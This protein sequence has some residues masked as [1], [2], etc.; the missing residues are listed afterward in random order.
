MCSGYAGLAFGTRRVCITC[1]AWQAAWNN[2]SWTAGR[3][4]YLF[5]DHS[6]SK[7]CRRASL[8]PWVVPLLHSTA[9]ATQRTLPLAAA[10]R[11]A[12]LTDGPSPS[13]DV[14]HAAEPAGLG[15]A[16]NAPARAAIGTAQRCLACVCP[17]GCNLGRH[18]PTVNEAGPGCVVLAHDARRLT[19]S[20]SPA[21]LGPD[22]RGWSCASRRSWHLP[23]LGG[24][25]AVAPRPRR[26]HPSPL[27]SWVSKAALRSVSPSVLPPL[28]LRFPLAQP[29]TQQRTRHQNVYTT[30]K[31][32][33]T[34][35]GAVTLSPAAAASFSSA[36]CVAGADSACGMAFVVVVIGCPPAAAAPPSSAV[37]R[38]AVLPAL[39]LAPTA[40][41]SCS[42]P[43]WY[44]APTR[45]SSPGWSA[46]AVRSSICLPS[47]CSWAW[48]LAASGERGEP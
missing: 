22:Q 27:S 32:D 19:A 39:S 41:S 3:H 17:L 21:G 40:F 7:R 34:L 48:A 30:E 45:E 1:L 36:R 12:D 47:A 16:T 23:I 38:F 20:C 28:L 43:E 31:Q 24:V 26:V 44:A 14:S 2:A 6:H 18:R 42:T 33:Y 29:E 5:T 8:M 9:S 13:P 37:V 11:S 25:A 4:L 35:G 15:P 46:V 10:T